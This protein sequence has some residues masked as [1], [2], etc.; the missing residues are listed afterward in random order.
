[1]PRDKRS[2]RSSFLSIGL[3]AALSVLSPAS[4]AL[5][6][7]GAF[8]VVCNLEHGGISPENIGKQI[9]KGGQD[10]ANAI[11]ELQANTVTG[12]ALEQAIIASRNTAINGAMPIPPEIRRAL[13]G[14]ASEDSMNRVRYKIGDNGA[15]NLA[16][17][18]E[19]GGDAAAVTLIDVVVFRGPSEAADPSIWA[20]ELTH[21]DQYASWG[22]HSFAVQYTRNFRSVEDPA[23]AKGNGY[24]AWAA[25]NTNLSATFPGSVSGQAEGLQPYCVTP[26]GAFGPDPMLL[27][28]A[29]T[30]CWHA[31]PNGV[32]I[33]GQ[34][35]WG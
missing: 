25:T 24:Q 19:Q 29:G 18:L 21:V 31:F 13:T 15:L 27:A 30:P 22:V 23:Y 8:D 5:A 32:V 1:M 26:A 16:H 35:A 28:P 7:G 34:V 9:Q 3:A 33:N 12:P 11:N 20:H 10:A 4:H 2:Y 6:C 14:Y 17:V